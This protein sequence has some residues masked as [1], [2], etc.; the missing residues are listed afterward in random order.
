MNPFDPE[1]TKEIETLIECVLEP[2]E[3]TFIRFGNSQ[4]IRHMTQYGNGPE[5]HWVEKT[6]LVYVNTK[7]GEKV[8]NL[9]PQHQKPWDMVE[10]ACRDFANLENELPED[11]KKKIS[12][13]RYSADFM[14]LRK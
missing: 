12:D 11:V 8:I 5:N 13:R 14:A 10:V 2:I 1:T 3:G 7:F 6:Y 4:E 9:N